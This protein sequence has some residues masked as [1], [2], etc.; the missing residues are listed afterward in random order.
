LVSGSSVSVSG[1][2]ISV[3]DS[4]GSRRSYFSFFRVGRSQSIVND[5]GSLKMFF[6]T[7]PRLGSSLSRQSCELGWSLIRQS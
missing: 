2:S 3:S 6:S 1:R 4:P 7:Y 5:F